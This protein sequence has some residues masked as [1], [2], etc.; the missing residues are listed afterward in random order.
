MEMMTNT[1]TIEPRYFPAEMSVPMAAE[2][3]RS[4]GMRINSIYLYGL[5]SAG[6]IASRA[7]GRRL[8]VENS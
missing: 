6:V 1:A 5:V 4:H 8:L 7:E 2:Y 3:L